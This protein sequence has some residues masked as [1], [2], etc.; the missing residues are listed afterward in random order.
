MEWRQE[1][2][3]AVAT[4]AVSA[5]ECRGLR[6]DQNS[7]IAREGGEGGEGLGRRL[8]VGCRPGQ[9]EEK[10][11]LG[12]GFVEE[13]LQERRAEVGIFVEG[14]LQEKE[15]GAEERRRPG[16]ARKRK[17]KWRAETG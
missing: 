13:M 8:I 2:E 14:M 17:K 3:C 1:E 15:E 5:G 12:R 7:G 11:G 10:E 16:P 4:L 9:G 6:V